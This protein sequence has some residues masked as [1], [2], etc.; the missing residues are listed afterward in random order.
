MTRKPDDDMSVGYLHRDSVRR[1]QVNH[2]PLPSHIM[3]AR[4]CMCG[5]V[6]DLRDLPAYYLQL[7][8]KLFTDSNGDVNLYSRLVDDDGTKP[9]NDNLLC[10]L[11]YRIKYVHKQTDRI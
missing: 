9:T 11:C 7:P 1:L 5:N 2:V 8:Y 6:V 10:K 4:C 3:T